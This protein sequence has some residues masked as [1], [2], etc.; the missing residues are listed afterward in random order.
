MTVRLLVSMIA[1]AARKGLACI[2]ERSLTSS[3]T[4]CFCGAP[5]CSDYTRTADRR[6]GF[7]C[8]LTLAIPSWSFVRRSLTRNG[9]QK[10]YPGSIQ[11]CFHWLRLPPPSASSERG[12]PTPPPTAVSGTPAPPASSQRRCCCCCCCC[13]CTRHFCTAWSYAAVSSTWTDATS[14]LGTIACINRRT[15]VPKTGG[16][17]SC[18]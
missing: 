1:A 4:R 16:L 10:S 11:H 9:A 8:R 18:V 6:I 3:V 12:C 7:L 15:D 17:V 2:I 5:Y 14:I 13:C